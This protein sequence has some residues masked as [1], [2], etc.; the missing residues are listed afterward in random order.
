MTQYMIS[1]QQMQC[2][3]EHLT[4]LDRCLDFSHTVWHVCRILPSTECDIVPLLPPYL[5][6]LV[7]TTPL[8]RGGQWQFGG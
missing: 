4:H 5:L 7:L 6:Q 8:C 2:H 3:A 1:V